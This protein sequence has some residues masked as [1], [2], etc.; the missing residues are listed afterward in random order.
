MFPGW[1]GARPW[2]TAVNVSCYPSQVSVL[3]EHQ[4]LS[5]AD[6][7]THVILVSEA[8]MIHNK[9]MINICVIL[10]ENN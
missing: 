8:D 9:G 5:S 1:K 7:E 6:H 4:K 2:A 10:G 3:E